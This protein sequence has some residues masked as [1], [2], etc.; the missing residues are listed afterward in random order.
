MLTQNC[1]WCFLPLCRRVQ[2]LLAALQELLGK[3]QANWWI[4]TP[5]G[6][7]KQQL[8]QLLGLLDHPITVPVKRRAESSDT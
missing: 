7:P 4:S 5:Q 2:G 8:L 6:K 3:P 1:Q